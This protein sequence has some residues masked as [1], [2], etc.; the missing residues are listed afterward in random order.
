MKDLFNIGPVPIGLDGLL[1]FCCSS[2]ITI[3][4]TY[5]YSVSSYTFTK[6]D[7]NVCGN[8]VRFE[9]SEKNEDPGSSGMVLVNCCAYMDVG[10]GNDEGLLRIA[11]NA[12]FQGRP[13]RPFLNPV[14]RLNDSRAVRP[15]DIRYMPGSF[16][17]RLLGTYKH[18]GNKGLSD[19][20]QFDDGTR[21]SLYAAAAG[22]TVFTD[23]FKVSRPGWEGLPPRSSLHRNSSVYTREQVDIRL[24]LLAL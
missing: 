19:I 15:K 8:A 21:Y 12:P 10:E 13:G 7:T 11:L 18:R 2:S 6:V 23:I 16:K 14:K 22:D 9:I 5:R 4:N 24:A 17:S 20:L 1:Q 3:L